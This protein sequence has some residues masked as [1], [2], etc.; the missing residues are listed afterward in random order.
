MPLASE[1]NMLAVVPLM[2]ILLPFW[3]VERRGLLFLR[4]SKGGILTSRGWFSKVLRQVWKH[5]IYD[6]WTGAATLG[7]VFYWPPCFR[8][9]W[10]ETNLISFINHKVALWYTSCPWKNGLKR[11]FWSYLLVFQPCFGRGRMPKGS[12]V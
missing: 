10:S 7:M 4:I 5:D 3:R 6:L 12:H 2:L 8:F 9:L 11:D 1:R